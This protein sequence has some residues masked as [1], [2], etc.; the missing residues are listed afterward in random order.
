MI[1]GT[2]KD[3]LDYADSGVTGLKLIAIEETSCRV[4]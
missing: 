1:N 2:A 4:A 3:A